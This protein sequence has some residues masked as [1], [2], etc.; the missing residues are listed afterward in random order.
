MYDP[1]LY[2]EIDALPTLSVGQADDLKID[3]RLLSHSPNLPA[4]V[5]G[6]ILVWT[7]RVESNTIH[8]ERYAGGTYA[9]SDEST[10]ADDI[11][12]AVAAARIDGL[13]D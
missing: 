12:A 1:T 5:D 2:R 3:T 7:S 4:G 11:A 9:D 6:G 10:E 8:A 13:F